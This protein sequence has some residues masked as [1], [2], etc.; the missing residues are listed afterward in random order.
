MA[1]TKEEKPAV[2]NIKSYLEVATNVAVLLV[3][4]AVLVSLGYSFYQ[5][6]TT[7]RT[8][9]QSETVLRKGAVLD[10]VR[11]VDFQTAPKT[12][13]LLLNTDCRYCAESSDFYNILATSSTVVDGKTNIIALFPNGE[14]QIREYQQQQRLSFRA[15]S[16]PEFSL[17]RRTGTPTLILTNPNRQIIDFWIGKLSSE[18]EQEVRNALES[19]Q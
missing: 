8:R 4:I 11:G 3:A 15:L 14:N 12:L 1:D 19:V 2:S 6:R 13:L 18:A 7:T 5:S 9:T 16:S 17:L 10:Q